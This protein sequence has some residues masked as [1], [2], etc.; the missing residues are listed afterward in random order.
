MKLDNK[1]EIHKYAID[2]VIKRVIR[3]L[4]L[5]CNNIFFEKTTFEL[6]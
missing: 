4:L 3:E 6:L 2:K 1:I 5:P